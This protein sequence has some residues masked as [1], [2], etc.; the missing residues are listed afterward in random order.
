MWSGRAYGADDA[1]E[2]AS[3]TGCCPK[4]GGCILALAFTWARRLWAMGYS[5][6]QGLPRCWGCGEHGQAAARGCGPDQIITS[7]AVYDAVRSWVDAEPY[8]PVQ[9]KGGRRLTSCMRWLG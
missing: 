3:T 5:F 8:G 6:P 2:L 7:H 1:R 4:T 9:L